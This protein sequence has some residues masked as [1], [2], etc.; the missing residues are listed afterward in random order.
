MYLV[1]VCHMNTLNGKEWLNSSVSLWLYQADKLARLSAS[2]DERKCAANVHEGKILIQGEVSHCQIFKLSIYENWIQT[3]L[4][5]HII[6]QV[7]IKLYNLNTSNDWQCLYA[8]YID[9]LTL[10]S[11]RI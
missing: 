3:P 5:Y 9:W 8:K 7:S 10:F 6:I 4:T 11:I 2:W 1:A